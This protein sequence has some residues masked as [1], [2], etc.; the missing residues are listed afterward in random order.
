MTARIFFKLLLIAL[1][2]LA[3]AMAAVDYFATRVVESSYRQNLTKDLAEKGRLI[4]LTLSSRTD[5][6]TADKI[7]EIARD[8]SGRLT[9]IGRDGHVIIDS[10]A[11]PARMENHAGRPEFVQAL[12]GKAGSAVRHSA[13]TGVDYLY[14]AIPISHGALRLA[15]PLSEVQAQVNS[16]R[17]KML[18]ATVVG[19]LP[20]I[21]IAAFFA[22]LISKQ[23]GAI[24]SFA[25]ELA[26]GNFRARLDSAGSPLRSSSTDPVIEP[27][28]E[29]V[30]RAVRDRRFTDG[31]NKGIRTSSPP[32]AAVSI[33]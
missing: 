10:E 17:G 12:A 23:L 6:Q 30:S 21:L 33:P 24:I 26:R 19:F 3:V 25:G 22:R 31:G 16:I 18:T 27:S 5:Q 14:V 7:R 28:G 29:S 15:A 2:L 1:C 11:E 13:T 9:V 8:A 4:D 32:S 20:A